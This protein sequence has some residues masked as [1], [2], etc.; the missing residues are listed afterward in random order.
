MIITELT[1]R[2]PLAY[3][4][5]AP[6]GTPPMD[7][8]ANLRSPVLKREAISNR[9][10]KLLETPASQTKQSSPPISNRDKIAP[11]LNVK[12]AAGTRVATKEHGNTKSRSVLIGGRRLTRR[13]LLDFK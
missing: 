8:Y 7:A 4:R 10:W 1:R 5:W 11:P 12:N 6:I 3:C 2:S 9:D 13:V